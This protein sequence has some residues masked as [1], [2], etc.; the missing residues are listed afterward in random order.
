MFEFSHRSEQSLPDPVVHWQTPVIV[1]G[2]PIQ[3]GWFVRC[4][5]PVTYSPRS[6]WRPV[7]TTSSSVLSGTQNPF[8]PEHVASAPSAEPTGHSSSHCWP[9]YPVS[10]SH[11]DREQYPGRAPAPSAAHVA[12]HA[13]QVSTLRRCD[14]HVAE[15]EV[16]S[17]KG[18]STRCVTLRPRTVM[19]CCACC[20]SQKDRGVKSMEH[21]SPSQAPPT[22]RVT[23]ERRFTRS[24]MAPS[25]R[26]RSVS[27]HPRAHVST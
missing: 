9:S 21:A 1:S 14:E 13:S 8:A 25:T 15:H 24:Q 23:F 26:L 7:S 20:V 22:S 10:Q 27:M 17:R 19:S 2:P 5:S 3:S 18:S 6:C 4:G 12:S 16:A 11:D